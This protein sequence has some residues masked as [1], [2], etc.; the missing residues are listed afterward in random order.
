MSF[1]VEGNWLPSGR[2]ECLWVE[3]GVLTSQRPVGAEIAIR[4]VWITPGLV[5]AHC[6]I[7]LAKLGAA[8]DEDTVNQAITDRDTGVLLVRDTGVPRDT[9]FLDNRPDMPRI[10]RSGQHIARFKRYIRNYAIEAEP[11]ELVEVVESQAARP[12]SQWVKLVGDWI[13]RDKGD[14]AP[15]WPGETVRAAVAKAH[16]YGKRVQVHTFAEQAVSEFVDA[17]VDCVEHGTGLSDEIIAKMAEKN[18]ALVPTMTQLA[19]FP[20]LAAGGDEKY[21][22]W[23][24]H[25]RALHAS[26]LEVMGKAM[27]AGVAIY[28]GTDAGGRLVHGRIAQETDLLAKVGGAEFALGAASWRAREWLGAPNINP[29]EPAD[30][31]CYPR[32]PRK[33]IS[34]VHTPTAIVLK[35]N[36]IKG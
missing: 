4:D 27:D 2:H 5:D 23:A 32:D 18:V 21:P 35:G 26:H 28:A 9:H 1:G 16:E 30:F 36:R 17:G 14:L 12:D 34:V 6:H 13:D 8:S 29:G 11:D 19:T 3:N 15:L 20:E 33:D 31:V 7:G 22:T 25:M 10:I 24:K